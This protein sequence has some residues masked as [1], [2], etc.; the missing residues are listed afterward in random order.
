MVGMPAV[1]VMEGGRGAS[2]TPQAD[3]VRF[4]ADAPLLIELLRVP[5]ALP[6]T[7]QPGRHASLPP[8]R[9]VRVDGHGTWD[10][11]ADMDVGHGRGHGYGHGHGHVMDMDMDM[12][13]DMD[14]GRE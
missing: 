12:D 4:L 11:D 5:V 1:V 9:R 3:R 14:K 2:A 7:A 10:M 8:V 6:H 13:V